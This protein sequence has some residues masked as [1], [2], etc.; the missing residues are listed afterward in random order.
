MTALRP[1]KSHGPVALKFIL[2]DLS[3]PGIS[4]D[5]VALDSGTI[6]PPKTP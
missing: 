3:L 1:S 5:Q 6:K 2:L 4:G